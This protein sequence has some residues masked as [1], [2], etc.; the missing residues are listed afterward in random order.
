MISDRFCP[1]GPSEVCSA[2]TRIPAETPKVSV[3]S[4]SS[5]TRFLWRLNREPD[6]VASLHKNRVPPDAN[7]ILRRQIP[8]D[9]KSVSDPY[10]WLDRLGKAR[11]ADCT[12]LTQEL[13]DQVGPPP[14]PPLRPDMIEHFKVINLIA[15]NA[16]DRHLRVYLGMNGAV[17][18]A[19]KVAIRNEARFWENVRDWAKSMTS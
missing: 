16:D 11:P 5:R 4:G 10:E 13:V 7:S 1:N 19:E 15:L 6:S 12:V 9:V 17:S 3:L 2:T 8:K 18:D 14:I